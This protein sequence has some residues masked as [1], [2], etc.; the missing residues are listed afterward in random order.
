MAA[1]WQEGQTCHGTDPWFTG[2]LA[3]AA[4]VADVGIATGR[5]LRGPVARRRRNTLPCPAGRVVVYFGQDVA[6][7]VSAVHAAELGAIPSSGLTF[8][9]AGPAA[10]PTREEA[11]PAVRLAGRFHSMRTIAYV[12]AAEQYRE[13][14]ETVGVLAPVVRA[15][16]LSD[17]SRER[18]GL[19][20]AVLQSILLGAPRDCGSFVSFA[21]R[22]VSQDFTGRLLRS[23]RVGHEV[24]LLPGP[25]R[26]FHEEERDHQP[27]HQCVPGGSR[28]RVAQCEGHRQC[29]EE[30][31]HPSENSVLF[32]GCPQR[33]A[34]VD[35][36]GCQ[37]GITALTA[38]GGTDYRRPV[39]GVEVSGSGPGPVH[40]TGHPDS[41]EGAEEQ[42]GQSRAYP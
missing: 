18:H 12:A 38:S 10:R 25:P 26:Q 35:Y 32:S 29:G 16:G 41:V 20:A 17:V 4:I 22:V 15:A 27:R 36:G 24:R 37:S 31:D 8:E 21:G 39:G 34:V 6:Q 13:A 5:G 11:V 19:S 28:E 23:L 3:V 2:C 40:P 14:R 30:Q 7:L 42:G 33:A 9:A 1:L